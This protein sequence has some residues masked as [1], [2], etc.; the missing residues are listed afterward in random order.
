MSL[1][2]SLYKK[3]IKTP[4]ETIVGATSTI[5]PRIGYSEFHRIHF[6]Y[7]TIYS[8]DNT[9]RVHKL[10]TGETLS[11][12]L[13]C[14]KSKKTYHSEQELIN[15]GKIGRQLEEITEEEYQQL[16]KEVESE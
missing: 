6:E 2:S 15:L 16:K 4:P 1:L 5:F 13:Y 8:S 10:D 7:Y 14:S 3:Y 9:I 12:E 11:V